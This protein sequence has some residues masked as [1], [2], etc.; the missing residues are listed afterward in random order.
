MSALPPDR[1]ALGIREN[2]YKPITKGKYEVTFA[3]PIRF[4]GENDKM[5]GSFSFLTYPVI[6]ILN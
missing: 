1:Y 2:E 3:H 5:I 6:V 4:Y